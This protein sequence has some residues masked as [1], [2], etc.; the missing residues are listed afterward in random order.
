[1]QVKKKQEAKLSY[2]ISGNLLIFLRFWLLI[3]IIFHFLFL[4]R[5]SAGKSAGKILYETE[6]N[7]WED[8]DPDDDLEL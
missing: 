3:V 8:E 6:I 5:K 4:N 1:M 2:H 7:D